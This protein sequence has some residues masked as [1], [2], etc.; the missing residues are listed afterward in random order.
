MK[1]LL[2][3][4]YW[5][6]LITCILFIIPFFWLHPN[7]VDLGGDSTRLYFYDPLNFLINNSLY[8]NETITLTSRSF[9]P[10]F[11]TLP[12]VLMLLLI[13]SIVPSSYFLVSLFNGIKVSISFLS[14]YLIIRMI[15]Q[16][17]Y[18]EKREVLLQLPAILGGLL[19]TTAP[20]VIGNYTKALIT[21][22]QIFLNPLCFYFLLSY[23]VKDKFRYLLV[24]LFITLL[25]AP[26]FSW[27]GAPPF[28]AFYPLT[29]VFL[30]LYVIF[31]LKKP[32]IYRHLFIACILF[33]ALHAFHFF[34]EAYS[35]LAPDSYVNQRVF[36]QNMILD[37][38]NY[39]GGVLPLSKL[40]LNILLYAP[41]KQFVLLSG[42]PAFFLLLGLCFNRNRDRTLF[43]VGI[44]FLI[45]LYL[46]T[47]NITHA[48][49]KLYEQF[50]Y[51]PG[52]S[53]FRN[54]IGQWAFVNSF[55]YVLLF[56]LAL[57]FLYRKI[58]NAKILLSVT[59]VI[60]LSLILSSWT[61]LTGGIVNSNL[62][63]SKVKIP[64]VMDPKF[65]QTINYIRSLT[66]EGAIV[67][68]PFTDCCYTIIHGINNGAYV[69]SLPIRTLT[70]KLEYDGYQMISP[71][72]EIFFKLV[73]DKNY[74]GIKKLLGLLNIKYIYYNDDPKVYDTEYFPSFPYGS[75]KAVFPKS[76]KSYKVFIKNIAGNQIYHNGT[77]HIYQTERK[78]FHP[79][80][81]TAED[82]KTYI[83]SQ[84]AMY[85]QTEPFYDFS[86][87]K[88]DV[89]I[90]QSDCS[91]I[92]EKSL[93]SKKENQLNP[94]PQV[95]VEEVNPTVYRIH[96][97]NAKRDYMLVFSKSFD[98]QWK[99]SLSENNLWQDLVSPNY[100][101]LSHFMVNGYANAWYI[102][103]KDIGNNS[104]YML[105]IQLNDQKIFYI[106]LFISLL[107]LFIF[108]IYYIYL[109]IKNN[110]FRL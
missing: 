79:L 77:Y 24:F 84:T 58:K 81:Y 47:A 72:D 76:Q 95:Q 30:L 88:N 11:Y 26:N 50:F 33:F 48:G 68:F 10:E 25:F 94:A 21:H 61:F 70:G 12:Y 3:N 92:L 65:E 91:Q 4:K 62:D 5:V 7:E 40:S 87:K 90:D 29:L 102:Q 13:K 96:I 104:D 15:I 27:A 41:Y 75:S 103:Q 28:F 64:M 80:F 55:F 106:G 38:L 85:I 110:R 60:T 93:C 54:F 9:W 42:I 53:M 73:N 56:G 86:A 108:I 97:H 19:Y 23:F 71:F 37:D 82:L 14:V 43:L 16:N 32:I 105:T 51:I 39:F 49:V 44:F 20:I 69:G 109:Y 8:L 101:K 78:F 46:V 99:I 100:L 66:N 18:R 22:D 89:F 59:I 17:S 98:T 67:S 1:S 57:Y 52:F 6:I 74:E 45:T 63:Q 31:I 35:L 107:T 36:S 83:A 2:K 34:P